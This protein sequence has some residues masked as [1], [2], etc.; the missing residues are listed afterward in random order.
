MS[1][2]ARAKLIIF[3]QWTHNGRK[4]KITVQCNCA[5]RTDSKDG[6]GGGGDA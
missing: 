6:V 3:N 2:R 4:L 1:A 5:K